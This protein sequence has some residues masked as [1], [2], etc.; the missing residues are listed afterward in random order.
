[1]SNFANDYRMFNGYDENGQPVYQEITFE[2]IERMF[3][4][5]FDQVTR[6]QIIA[7]YVFQ[8]NEEGVAI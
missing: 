7:Q 5:S 6:E 8:V 1:M 2:D 3:P 4:D